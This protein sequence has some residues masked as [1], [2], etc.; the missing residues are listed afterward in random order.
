MG[1]D[2]DDREVRVGSN[3]LTLKLESAHARHAH[4]ENQA[5]RLMHL[6]RL[7]E[8]FRRREPLRSQ[9]DGSDQILERTP[10]SLVIVDNRNEWNSWHPKFV[11]GFLIHLP[12]DRDFRYL[13]LKLPGQNCWGKSGSYK[14]RKPTQSRTRAIPKFRDLNLTI[15]GGA[16]IY[17]PL[18]DQRPAECKSDRRQPAR[19]YVLH[20]KNKRFHTMVFPGLTSVSVPE[21]VKHLSSCG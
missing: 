16:A 15:I 7:Q 6:I 21:V 20:K 12:Q 1:R 14:V 17:L 4:I 19:F 3:H 2:K 18:V 11:A 13:A 8:R 9:S 5:V 10:E